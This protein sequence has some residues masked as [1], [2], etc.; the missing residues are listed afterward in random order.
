[1]P[2]QRP[3]PDLDQLLSVTQI[4]EDCDKLWFQEVLQPL[5]VLGRKMP[6]SASENCEEYDAKIDA[7]LS[8]R[9]QIYSRGVKLIQNEFI[10]NSDRLTT[11]IKYKLYSTLDDPPKDMND[12]STALISDIEARIERRRDRNHD[13]DLVLS[14]IEMAKKFEDRYKSSCGNDAAPDAQQGEDIIAPLKITT[15]ECQY[16]KHVITPVRYEFRLQCN[17][18]TEKTD[19]KLKKR[20]PDIPKGSAHNASRG[21]SSRG[22]VQGPRGPNILFDDMADIEV[23]TMKGPLTSEYKDISQFSLEYN[24]WGNLVGFNFQ[25]SEDGSTLKDPDSVESGV[26]SRWSWNAIASPKKGY[27]YRL[28]SEELPKESLR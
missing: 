21:N 19:P 4:I 8:K 18:I 12:L 2:L 14:L 24:K 26:D 3:R 20:K 17:T 11:Y 6:S 15:V 25:L 27:M 22:P 16:I 13:Y 10:K 1:M 9:K 28:L 5:E 23:A 7:Y